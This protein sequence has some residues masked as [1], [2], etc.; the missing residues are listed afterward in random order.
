[1]LNWT[2]KTKKCSSKVLDEGPGLTPEG[3]E[4]KT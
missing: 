1:M 4:L 3:P 2:L